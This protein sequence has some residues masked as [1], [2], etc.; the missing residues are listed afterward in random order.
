MIIS[1]KEN[2]FSYVNNTVLV[3]IS[4]F[5]I[6]PLIY[7]FSSSLSSGQM[8]TAGE[9]WFWPR[10][11]TLSAYAK[12][13]EDKNIWVSYGNTFFYTIFGT[14]VSMIFTICGAYPLSKKRLRGRTFFTI[15]IALTMW[16]N[17]GQIPFYLNLKDLNM[18]DSRWAIIIAFAV[19]TY[20]VIIMKTFFQSLPD[21]LEEA[22]VIEGANDYTILWNIFLPLSTP[23]LITIGLFYAVARWNGYFWAMVL[24]KDEM[25]LPLQ[26]LLKKKIVEVSSS[27]EYLNMTDFSA[28]FSQETVIYATMVIAIIPM[29]IV[30]PYIQRFF[31]K[32]LTVGAIKG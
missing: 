32:G 28:N 8:V 24:L 9:V 3:I 21:A 26:V 1:K 4:L 23:S 17:A 7:V 18:L 11:F 13:F 5:L 10:E 30:Y 20:Y 31:I 14:F 2:L 19:N 15:F 25:K 6:Y 29:L 22:A 12:V 16:I 27:V